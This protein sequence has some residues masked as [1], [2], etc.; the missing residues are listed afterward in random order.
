MNG[1]CKAY[2]KAWKHPVFN[3][4]LEASIW[5]YLYQ[6]AFWEDG[7]KNINGHIFELERGQIVVTISYLTKGFCM[8]KSK[9]QT[10]LQKLEK[11]GM[12]RIKSGNR[13]SVI[14]I[15]NYSLYQEFEKPI[16]NEIG[17]RSETDRKHARNNK[18]EGKNLKKGKKEI[19]LPIGVDENIWN[20]FIKI[21]K[22]LKA[23][24]TEFAIKQLLN[25]LIKI[26]KETGDNPNEILLQSIESSWKG[27]FPIRKNQQSNNQMSDTQK[28][29]MEIMNNLETTGD[30]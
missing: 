27:V 11:H 20:E 16:G 28:Q 15:C 6:N 26:S 9:I 19:I 23:Q 8:S 25:N 24:N 3:N 21:R 18:K 30:W 29:T 2:R 13:G 7:I 22:K 17:N 4:L 1:F 12:I 14:T 5:N 10:V